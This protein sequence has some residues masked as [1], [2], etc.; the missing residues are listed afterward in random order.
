MSED[1]YKLS[2]KDLVNKVRLERSEQAWEV[3]RERYYQRIYRYC[4]E[5]LKNVREDEINM[6]MKKTFEFDT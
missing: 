6:T 2:D 3:L 4:E 1:F 5:I